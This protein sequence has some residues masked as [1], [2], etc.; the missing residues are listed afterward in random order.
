MMRASFILL[1]F[2]TF[3][4]FSLSS[5][6]ITE[7]FIPEPE[8]PPLAP[9]FPEEPPR[10][11]RLLSL[12]MSLDNLKTA[13]IADGIFAFRGD[14]DVSFLPVLEETLVET[15]GSSFI[16][17]AH[18]QLTD[19]MVYLMSFS[20]NTRIIDHFSVFTAFVRR[21]GEPVSLSP[22]E[23]VWESENTRV[24]IERPLTVKY[25]DKTVFDSLVEES[26]LQQRREVFAR[27]EFL[28]DF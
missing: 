1:I 23:A 18:F 9:E 11:F 5:Q 19:E 10:Q 13:L 15:T 20:L 4:G 14:R 6:E 25:L 28:G 8:R 24:S 22:S 3:F 17:R 26:R 21:Y 16:R 7:L 2:F 27:E 12:G